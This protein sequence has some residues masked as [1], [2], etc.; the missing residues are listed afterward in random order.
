MT[1]TIVVITIVIYSAADRKLI[2]RFSI[3]CHKTNTKISTLT[4][5]NKC[6]RGN[7]VI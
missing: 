7:E 4:N 1:K 5:H 2:E 6:K 3:E